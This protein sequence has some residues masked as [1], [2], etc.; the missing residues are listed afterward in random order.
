MAEGR[1]AN[2]LRSVI[3]PFVREALDRTAEPATAEPGAGGRGGKPLALLVTG[4]R[5]TAGDEAITA[6][7]DQFGFVVHRRAVPGTDDIEWARLVVVT[8]NAGTAAILAVARVQVPL[9][10]WHGFDPL[11]LAHGQTLLLARERLCIVEPADPVAAGLHGVVSVHRGP[12]AVTVAEVGPD[13]R[14]VAR[15]IDDDRP[16]VFHYPAGTRL[17]DGTTAPAHRTGLFLGPDGLAPWLLTEAGRA[18]VRAGLRQHLTA[19]P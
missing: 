3:P 17:C 18:I 19:V 15:V 5:R 1:Y 13:A 8:R 14:V 12:A 2:V 9:V 10:A 4:S 7:L 6:L 11:G 16:A